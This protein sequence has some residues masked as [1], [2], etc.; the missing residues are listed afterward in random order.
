MIAVCNLSGAVD[1]YDY[2][3]GKYLS[4]VPQEN[5]HNLSLPV[6][7]FD[8]GDIQL[9]T[10]G[11]NGQAVIWDVSSQKRLATLSHETASGSNS[12]DA[13]IQNVTV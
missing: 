3:S 7:L 8:R 10:G 4:Y 5:E 9:L 2:R 13:I 6:R 1:L 12:L 11:T